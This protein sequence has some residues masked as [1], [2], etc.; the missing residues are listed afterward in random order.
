MD[1]VTKKDFD[2]AESSMASGGADTNPAQIYPIFLSSGSQNY[3][4]YSNPQ[5]DMLLKQA[6]QELD[7]K[8]QKPLYAQIQQTLMDELPTWYAW[9]RPFLH[10]VKKK[11]T[12]Y[13]DSLGPGGIFNAL[14][15]WSING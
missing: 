14:Q 10:V 11:F 4:S 9:Y 12:G 8:K 13:T 2:V 1:R 7:I 3:S 6:T 5:V 15:N